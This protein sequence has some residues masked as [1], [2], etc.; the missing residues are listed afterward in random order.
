MQR[1]EDWIDISVPLRSAMVSWPGD[2]PV[3]IRRV[4]SVEAG[5]A[6]TVSHLSFGSHTGTHMDSPAHF[7]GGGASIDAVPWHA[8]M[9]R[10]RVLHL[11]GVRVVTA[12]VLK[13]HAL[14]KR[15]RLLLK[16]DNSTAEWWV[17]PFQKDFVHLDEGAASYL[18]ERG[19]LLIGVDYLSVS[20]YA[21][22]PALVHRALLA[23][24][25]WIVEGLNLVNVEAGDYE[26][27]CLPLKLDGGDGA[28][29]R[30]LLRKTT[31][32]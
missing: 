8:V 20:G 4:S 15:E 23:N 31:Q 3:E 11:P 13:Q 14:G 5:D 21:D 32:R 9:G 7:I 26:L 17:R 27:V 18:A 22:N 30:A 1:A 6:A 28:P 25:V 2:P 19:T 16:T 24:G 12:D 10:A 29:A